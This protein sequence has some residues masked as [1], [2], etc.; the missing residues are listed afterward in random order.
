M[1]EHDTQMMNQILDTRHSRVSTDQMCLI[2]GVG[3]CLRVGFLLRGWD[4]KFDGFHR[5]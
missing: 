5:I 4:E 3:I 1:G 2:A